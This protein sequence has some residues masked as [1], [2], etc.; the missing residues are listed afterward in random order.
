MK[1]RILTTAFLFLGSLFSLSYAQKAIP[2]KVIQNIH[3]RVDGGV[4]AG[5]VVGLIDGDEVSY[6]SYG[7]KSVNG[8]DKVDEHSVF[9]IGSISKT[10]TGVLLANMVQ[11][12][13]LRLE[14]PLSKH[15]PDDVK[16]PGRNGEVIRLVE[17]ANH[18]SSLPRMPTNFT[19][20][21]PANPYADYTEKQMLDFLS[22]V[23]LSRDIGSQ[24]EYSNFAMGLLGHILATKNSMS[25]EDLMVKIIADPLGMKNTRITFTP[26]MKVNLAMGH[27]G[28]VEVENWDIP[29]LAGAGAI[30]STT[31]DMVKYIQANMGMNKAGLY[32]AMQLSHTN[33][34]KDGEAPIVGLAWHTMNFE[35]DGVEIVWH[36]G[37]TGGYRTF[38][39]FAKGSNKGVVVL[40]NSNAGVDDI[41]IHL[42]NPNSPLNKV[43]ASIAHEIR[44][45]ID[46]EGIDAAVKAYWKLKEKKADDFEFG[47]S[48]LNTLGYQYLAKNEFEKAIAVF[49]LNV[50]AYP[51]GFNPYDS[52]GEAY[53]KKGDNE[54]AIANYTKSVEINPG[55]LGGLEMLKKL[56]VDTDALSKEVI[57]SEEILA[58][59]VGK[60][61]LIPNFILTITKEGK[62]MKA[63]ATG[64]ANF[65]IFPSAENVF[66]YKVI[67]AQITFNQNEE[68]EVTSITFLQAGQKIEGKKLE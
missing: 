16:V 42:L 37:G 12:G 55:N 36:N 30:R 54:N 62:Q 19:P 10:F 17:M 3:A 60:Y 40:S 39:G 38:A 67:Q 64:Q 50:E 9:E 48:E 41:G 33:T 63:Q 14:D 27:S 49:K 47:E 61:E 32:P 25:Y 26:D 59:Y 7:L 52:L 58:T 15:L 56:G 45:T 24:Y 34:R 6:Y 20:A 29:T 65:D 2:E 5:I 51:D 31:V 46:D 44:K 11:A 35:D 13:K 8:T 43:K 57:V 4:N 53:M 66:Y 1:V 68:G 18:T 22:S 23:E 28:G 21:N